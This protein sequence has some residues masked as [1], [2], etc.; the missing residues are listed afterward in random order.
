[1]TQPLYL[2]DIDAVVTEVLSCEKSADGQFEIQLAHTPFYPQ[3]GGQPS[4]L[5]TINNVPVMLVKMNGKKIIHYCTN[6]VALGTAYV[7]IDKDRRNYHSRLHSAGHLIA[8]LMQSLGWTPIKAQHWPN[9]A[10]IQVSSGLNTQNID[11]ESL[12]KMCNE[13]IKKGWITHISEDVEGYREVGFGHLGTFPCGGTHVKNLAEIVH[14]SITDM[15]VKK[16]VLNIKYMVSEE[17]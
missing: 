16:G 9:D 5:G 3:G 17:H 2:S 13:Y 1:M 4:D 14:I 7:A 10:K 8:H 15:K 12:E 11:L 6:E